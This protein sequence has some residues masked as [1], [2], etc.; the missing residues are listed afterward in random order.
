VRPCIEG[1]QEV[2]SRN[3]YVRKQASAGEKGVSHLL[4]KYADDVP[5]NNAVSIYK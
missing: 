1:R 2:S 3:K 5:S 4:L